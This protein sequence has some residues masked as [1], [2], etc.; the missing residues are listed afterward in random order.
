MSEYSRRRFVAIAGSAAASA[1][2]AATRSEFLAAGLHAAR[3]SRFETLSDADA[4]EIEAAA[5]QI[6]PTDETPGAREARVIYFID[7]ALSTFAKDEKD[8]ML[9]AVKQLRTHA[10]KAQ[11]GAKSFA[12]LSS[13][14]QIAILTAMEKDKKS[15]F[16]V[17]RYATISGM[18]AN[19]EWGGNYQK[20][21]WK[22][23]GFDDR[24]SWG[25]PFGWYDQNA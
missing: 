23:I 5:A 9:G 20:I 19:P 24:F 12:A 1:W 15:G 25:P 21:G 13:D 14:Q 4:A 22:W 7:K 2:F 17:L 18:L 8:A 11:A 16:G 6:I 3:A 10:A